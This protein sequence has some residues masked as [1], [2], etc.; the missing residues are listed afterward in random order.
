MSWGTA[1]AIAGGNIAGSLLANREN[2]Q[3]A[4]DQMAFQERMSSTAHQREVADLRAAGLNPILSANAGAS[5]PAGA[6]AHMENVMLEGVSSAVDAKRLSKEIDETD[7]RIAVN[8]AVKAAQEASAKRDFSTAKQ[9]DVQTK[10]LEAQLP[11]LQKQSQWDL[12]LMDY[13]NVSKRVQD[14]LGTFNSAK[15]LKRPHYNPK[16]GPPIRGERQRYNDA[17]N[18]KDGMERFYYNHNKQKG[19]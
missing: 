3:I 13:D 10:A 11:V 6:G 16:Q 18:S 2:R 14:V 4:N 8:E 5:T 17:I 15:D 12:K 1:A 9:A 19:D 7:S